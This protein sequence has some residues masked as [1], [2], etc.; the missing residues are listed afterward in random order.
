MF[1]TIR[2]DIADGIRVCATNPSDVEF[3]ADLLCEGKKEVKWDGD[4]WDDHD[5]DCH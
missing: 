5:E 2:G 3:L 1:Q 4:F